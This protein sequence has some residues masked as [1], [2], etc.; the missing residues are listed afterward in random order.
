VLF[1]TPSHE[2]AA[3]FR[4][5]SDPTAAEFEI[6]DGSR[7]QAPSLVYEVDDQLDL[8]RAAGFRTLAVR[9]V[10]LDEL[11]VPRLSDKLTLRELC[12]APILRGYLVQKRS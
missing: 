3:A 10:A 9:Q 8:T 11:D 12:A 2:W 4:R 6:A 5:D 1:T 7:V